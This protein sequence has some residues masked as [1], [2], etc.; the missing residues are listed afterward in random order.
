MSI[1]ATLLQPLSMNVV[2]HTLTKVCKTLS[3]NFQIFYYLNVD[4]TFHIVY[5]LNIQFNRDIRN[6]SVKLKLNQN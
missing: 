4:E 6:R 1:Y 2:L 5:K 3:N